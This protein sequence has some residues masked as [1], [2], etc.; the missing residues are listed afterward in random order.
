MGEILQFP[1]NGNVKRTS[2]QVS[3]YRQ[4]DGSHFFCVEKLLTDGTWDRMG[5]SRDLGEAWKL[6]GKLASD[7]EWE[8]LPESRW[9]G[10]SH[11]QL[12]GAV[13]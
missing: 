4:D 7:N 2:I 1:D 9:P 5:H 6:A 12:V 10:H 8:L 11:L 3:Y 13:Q